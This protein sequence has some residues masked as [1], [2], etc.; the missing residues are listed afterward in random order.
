VTL[1]RDAACTDALPVTGAGWEARLE[2]P[3]H[4]A[5]FYFRAAQAGD[6]TLTLTVT[7]GGGVSAAQG[8]TVE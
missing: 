4:E 7:G 1:Y 3:Q 5:V 6:L 8:Y 2:A